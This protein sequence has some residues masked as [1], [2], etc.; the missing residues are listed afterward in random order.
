M[1]IMSKRTL[2]DSV[3]VALIAT[4]VV[5]WWATLVLVLHR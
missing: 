3:G 5:A 1:R 4:I 2:Q